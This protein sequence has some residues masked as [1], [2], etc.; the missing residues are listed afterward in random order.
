MEKFKT[1]SDYASE[2]K[3]SVES[4]DMSFLSDFRAYMQESVR[5]SDQNNMMAVN[6]ASNMIINR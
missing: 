2:N 1:F 4:L 6:S 5:Q 3:I